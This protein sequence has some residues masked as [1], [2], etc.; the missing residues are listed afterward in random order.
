MTLFLI[1]EKII[2]ESEIERMEDKAKR[3]IEE[4]VE[5]GFNSSEPETRDVEKYLFV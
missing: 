4:A 3:E 5:Y 1:E 2:T